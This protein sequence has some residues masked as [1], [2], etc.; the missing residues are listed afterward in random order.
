MAKSP[1]YAIAAV[2]LSVA[3]TTVPA[4]VNPIITPNVK[5]AAIILPRIITS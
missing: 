4:T 3:A 2:P 5:G 1:V